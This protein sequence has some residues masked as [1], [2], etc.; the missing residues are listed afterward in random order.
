MFDECNESFNQRWNIADLIQ[1]YRMHVSSNW[2][3]LPDTWTERQITEALDENKAPDW[4]DKEQ[5]VYK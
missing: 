2:D 3:F 4:D 1:L 5:P